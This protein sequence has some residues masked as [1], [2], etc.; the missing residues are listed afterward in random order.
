VGGRGGERNRSGGEKKGRRERRR[1]RRRRRRR[2]VDSRLQVLS[3]T[4]CLQLL[5]T[6][7]SKDA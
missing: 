6:Y 2:S 7:N 4:T 5:L 1:R 3:L